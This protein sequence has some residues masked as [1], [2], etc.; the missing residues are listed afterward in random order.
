MGHEHRSAVEEA[1][2]RE[3]ARMRVLL[4]PETLAVLL[5]ANALV[6]LAVAQGWPG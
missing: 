5:V 4:L 2:L 6:W 3:A 1:S